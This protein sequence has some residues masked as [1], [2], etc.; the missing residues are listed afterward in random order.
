MKRGVKQKILEV[1]LDSTIWNDLS[2]QIVP[3]IPKRTQTVRVIGGQRIRD[4]RQ[5]PG[6]GYTVYSQYKPGLAW[7]IQD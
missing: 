3:K 4:K 6:L 2:F 5:W 1:S 7:N